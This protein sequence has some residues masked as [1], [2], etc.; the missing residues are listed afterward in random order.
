MNIKKGD[1]IKI[2]A[3]KDRGKTGKVLRVFPERNRIAVE[4]INLYK[5]HSRPKRQGEKGEI[6][7]IM[8]P[9]HISNAQIICSGCKQAT[10]VGHRMEGAVKIRY[11]KKCQLAV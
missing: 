7:E 1:N 6:V 2:I 8:R 5:K 4:G 9:F 11:C 10:R 3:G